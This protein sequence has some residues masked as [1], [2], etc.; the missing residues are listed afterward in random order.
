MTK[1]KKKGRGGEKDKIGLT[2]WSKHRGKGGRK[3]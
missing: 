3:D 2:S 1:N